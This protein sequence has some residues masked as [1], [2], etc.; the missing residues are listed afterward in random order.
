MSEEQERPLLKPIDFPLLNSDNEVVTY[1]LGNFDSVTG[2]EIITQYPMTGLPKIGDYPSNRELMYKLMSFVAVVKD[3]REIR[4]TTPALVMNHVETPEMLLK[5]EMKMMEKN[6]S[7]FRDGRSLDLLDIIAQTFSKKILE[8]LTPS[9]EPS[10][11]PNKPPTT[12]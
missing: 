3:G 4:L 5:I 1:K 6:C 8:L 11:P 12:N 10:S 7:F 9:S 2:R